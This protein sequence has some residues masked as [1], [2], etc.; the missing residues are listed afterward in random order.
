MTRLHDLQTTVGHEIHFMTVAGFTYE[1]SDLGLLAKRGK[2]SRVLRIG[3]AL[4]ARRRRY[5]LLLRDH[6]TKL[7]SA[8]RKRLYQIA[9]FRR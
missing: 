8:R 2:G 9:H 4:S 7:A 3:A 6:P 5:R 1:D